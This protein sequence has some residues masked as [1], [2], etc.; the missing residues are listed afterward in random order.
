MVNFE[1]VRDPLKKIGTRYL[2]RSANLGQSPDRD[3]IAVA[4]SLLKAISCKD[5]SSQK[6]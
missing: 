1:T 3:S 2:Q 6:A 5:C 4:H